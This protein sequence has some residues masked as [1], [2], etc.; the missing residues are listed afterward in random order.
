MCL[1]GQL[2]SGAFYRELLRVLRPGGRLF[3]YIGRPDSGYGARTGAGV[4]RRLRDAGFTGI[5]E[6]PAAVGV[7][8]ARPGRGGR[9]R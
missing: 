6:R 9:R 7:V 1:A 8:A 3:H 5:A 4:I 2:Y